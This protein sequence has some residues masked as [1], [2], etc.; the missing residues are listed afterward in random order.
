MP[1]MEEMR[2]YQEECNL[3]SKLESSNSPIGDWKLVKY[4]E[5]I[6][7]GLTPPYDIAE[8]YAQRQAIRDQLSV[9]TA[10][11][12][13]VNALNALKATR[14]SAVSKITVE[15]DGMV[16]DGDEKAQERMARAVVLADSMDEQTEWVLADHTVAIV[17]AAQL[18]K[19]CKLAGLAQTQLWTVPYA[20]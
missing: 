8:A 10:E 3:R 19:A 4:L 9:P 16:F 5:Y 14:A 12:Q 18:K 6:A 1:D 13:A 20:E 2:K 15:V 7:A 11:E 17:T